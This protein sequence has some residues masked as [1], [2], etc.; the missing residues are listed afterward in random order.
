MANG[1]ARKNATQGGALV[2]KYLPAHNITAYSYATTEHIAQSNTI[3]DMPNTREMI[4]A[5]FIELPPTLFSQEKDYT[6]RNKHT[7]HN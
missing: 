4:F 3:E 6:H 2:K 5:C 1:I 7:T